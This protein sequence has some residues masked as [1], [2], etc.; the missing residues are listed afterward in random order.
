MRT[1]IPIRVFFACGNLGGE[2]SPG[3]GTGQG[4]AMPSPL[5]VKITLEEQVAD[6]R[7]SVGRR[8][9]GTPKTLSSGDPSPIRETFPCYFFLPPAQNRPLLPMRS[10]VFHVRRFYGQGK[11]ISGSGFPQKAK[12]GPKIKALTK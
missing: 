1:R 8:W 11:N 9:G 5:N 3:Q 10:P 12:N 7:L 6:P 2:P 4:R